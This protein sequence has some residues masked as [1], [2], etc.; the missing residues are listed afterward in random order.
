[1]SLLERLLS[2]TAVD[3]KTGCWNWTASKRRDGYGN[4][5][6]DGKVR[7]A[8]RV[9]YELH[10]GE[11]PRG[12]G[13][14]G[15]CVLH[16]CDNRACVNPDHLFLGSQADNVADRDS[17]NRQA[18]KINRADV[19]SIRSAEGLTQQDLAGAF[20]ISQ[21]QVHRIRSGKK[22]KHVMGGQQ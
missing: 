7:L 3:G 5:W 14:H 8:H 20:G 1:M 9:S 6:H 2:K 11:I 15:T 17:K 18:S 4:A 13:H 10:H 16:K 19:L 12:D 22:W 21:T